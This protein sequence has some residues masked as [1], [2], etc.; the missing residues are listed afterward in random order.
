M[1]FWK[2]KTKYPQQAKKEPS[3]RLNETMPDISFDYIEYVHTHAQY[4]ATKEDRHAYERRLWIAVDYLTEKSSDFS[5]PG[6]FIVNCVHDC[7]A[8]LRAIKLIR[9]M[10]GERPPNYSAGFF[11]VSL[12]RSPSGGKDAN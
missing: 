5:C 8:A 2:R 11:E 3:K 9:E 6:D 12:S 1:P 4:M 10:K 7:L